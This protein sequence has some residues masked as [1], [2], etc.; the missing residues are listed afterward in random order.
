MVPRDAVHQLTLVAPRWAEE[1]ADDG[2]PYFEDGA[3]RVGAKPVLE[4]F[5]AETARTMQA[6]ARLTPARRRRARARRGAS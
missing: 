4:C 1:D 5:F 3:L 6:L 2:G